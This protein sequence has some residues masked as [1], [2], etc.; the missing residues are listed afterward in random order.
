MMFE[1]CLMKKYLVF[2]QF[3]IYIYTGLKYIINKLFNL[4]ELFNVQINLKRLKY[5][6]IF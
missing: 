1:K 6:F 2:Y 5:L 3:N 4:R